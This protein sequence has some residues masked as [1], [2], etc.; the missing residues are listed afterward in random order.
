MHHL[1]PFISAASI[2][3]SILVS[4]L[5]TLR[6][7]D[8]LNRR[9]GQTTHFLATPPGSAILFAGV[10]VVVWF[11]VSFVR[12]VLAMATSSLVVTGALGVSDGSASGSGYVRRA[13]ALGISATIDGL[14]LPAVASAR[15]GMANLLRQASGVREET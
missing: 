12:C 3:V 1:S 10:F 7:I 8:R 15:E 11:A 6:I 9:A 5:L 14:A 4:R 13:K 2:V